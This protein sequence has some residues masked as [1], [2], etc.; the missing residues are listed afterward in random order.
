MPRST[1]RVDVLFCPLLST[2][3]TLQIT[4]SVV[5][6]RSILKAIM[7]YLHLGVS[8]CCHTGRAVRFGV[9]CNRNKR[10][11]SLTEYKTKNKLTMAC[12]LQSS[13]YSFSF[14]IFFV[15]FTFEYIKQGIEKGVRRVFLARVSAM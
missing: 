10:T 15:R 14:I 8:V 11:E 12:E 6:Y 13:V 5:S 9:L 4:C 7:P 3:F 1:I 2:Q